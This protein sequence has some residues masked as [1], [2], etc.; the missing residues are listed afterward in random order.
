M[1][2]SLLVFRLNFTGKSISKENASF[3]E[4]GNWR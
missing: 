2:Q 4:S 3:I 1:A